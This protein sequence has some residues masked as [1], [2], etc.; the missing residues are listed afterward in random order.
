MT[1]DPL[2]RRALLGTGGAMAASALVSDAALA[3]ARP[4]SS[5]LERYLARRMNAQTIEL[6][7]SHA[8]L[9][10]HPDQIA[11]L[12]ECAARKAA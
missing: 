12:I 7:S 6:D 9:V 11:A 10:S 3:S 5:N 1:D 2:S 8:S 4:A